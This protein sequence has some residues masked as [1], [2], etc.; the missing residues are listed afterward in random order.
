MTCRFL[1][2]RLRVRRQTRDQP[3]G[4]PPR[5]CV[6]S[7]LTGP[8]FH[9]HPHRACHRR[10]RPVTQ[11]RCLSCPRRPSRIRKKSLPV[12]PHLAART[13]IPK[14]QISNLKFQMPSRKHLWPG[15]LRLNRCKTIS[16][17][18]LRCWTRIPPTLAPACRNRP[19]RRR[20]PTPRR[21]SHLASV[22][23]LPLP[24]RAA[25]ASH[26]IPQPRLPL[27]PKKMPPDKRLR[28]RSRNL[29]CRPVPAH[30]LWSCRP[31]P[32]VTIHSIWELALPGAPS[33]LIR[34]HPKNH[35]RGRARL[36]KDF[37][38][39]V[40]APGPRQPMSRLCRR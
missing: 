28:A 5:P 23:N 38:R 9:G 6:P 27:H 24:S 31:R 30:R 7:L 25:R 40:R 33:R 10:R 17:L 3:P 4:N 21:K 20:N 11:D 26:G 13:P 1:R 15:A 34:E 35:P 8:G 18:T 32:P 16:S 22:L 37:R 39:N 29:S 14:Y 2:R 19:F 12:T 36:R